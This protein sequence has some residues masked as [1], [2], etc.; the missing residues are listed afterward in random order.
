MNIYVCVFKITNTY[1]ENKKKSLSSHHQ[2]RLCEHAVD[3]VRV[4][5]L[6]SYHSKQQQSDVDFS[7]C[8]LTTTATTQTKQR[9]HLTRFIFQM[10]FVKYNFYTRCV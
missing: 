5:V 1:I 9:M 6:L 2:R 8:S 10:H 7:F 3:C 4:Q